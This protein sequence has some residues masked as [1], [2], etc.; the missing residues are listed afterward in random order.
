MLI[1][2]FSTGQLFEH[3]QIRVKNAER[4]FLYK[5]ANSLMNFTRFIVLV[6]NPSKTIQIQTLFHLEKLNFGQ[7]KTDAVQGKFNINL[8]KATS[9]FKFEK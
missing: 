7:Q 6:L 5:G 3:E 9:Y 2:V 8:V 4:I 1:A